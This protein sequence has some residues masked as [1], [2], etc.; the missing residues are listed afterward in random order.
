M[1]QKYLNEKQSM[2]N[3]RRDIKSI[4]SLATNEKSLNKTFYLVKNIPGSLERVNHNNSIHSYRD[5]REP[6]GNTNDN[7]DRKSLVSS[8]KSIFSNL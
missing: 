6:L 7:N 2:E 4:D 3:K 1:I 5:A 8:K